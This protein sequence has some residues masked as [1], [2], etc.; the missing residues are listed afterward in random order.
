MDQKVTFLNDSIFV[1]SAI[2]NV[3]E[4]ESDSFSLIL[5]NSGAQDPYTFS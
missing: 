3:I 4:F 2:E 5:F 1:Q